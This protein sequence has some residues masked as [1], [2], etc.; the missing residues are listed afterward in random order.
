MGILL[1]GLSRLCLGWSDNVTL[2][3]IKGYTQCPG[4]LGSAF[5]IPPIEACAQCMT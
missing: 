2:D 4:C 1:S 5:Y 3:N